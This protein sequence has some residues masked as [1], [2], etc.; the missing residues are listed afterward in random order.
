ML[1][2]FVGL[3][4]LLFL[5]SILFMI[6]GIEEKNFG[7]FILGFVFCFISIFSISQMIEK[8]KRNEYWL[9]KYILD[10]NCSSKIFVKKFKN[11]II[12]IQKEKTFQK[13]ENK[14]KEIK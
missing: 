8:Y 13:I 1:Y 9:V 14:Y 4:F 11:E 5:I 2:V 7:I 3:I 10:H 6:G 12:S